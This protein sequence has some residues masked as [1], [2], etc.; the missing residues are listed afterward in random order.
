M[1][2]KGTG[3]REQGTGIDQ[4]IAKLESAIA[5]RQRQQEILLQVKNLGV[6]LAAEIAAQEAATSPVKRA[7]KERKAAPKKL[8]HKK[9]QITPE[10]RRR[11]AE[12]Q[13]KRWKKVHSSQLSAVSRKTPA[14]PAVKPTIESVAPKATKKRIRKPKAAVSGLPS[15]ADLDRVA[16]ENAA[17]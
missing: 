3:N 2:K 15:A 12:A 8:A 17:T 4:A 1:K 7:T 16:E 14:R 10:G 5:T 13:R 11:I 6:E 9:G